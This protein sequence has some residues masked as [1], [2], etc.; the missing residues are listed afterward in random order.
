MHVSKRSALNDE[1]LGGSCSRTTRHQSRWF[2]TV[3]KFSCFLKLSRSYFITVEEEAKMVELLFS[4]RGKKKTE[5]NQA[6][7]G[8]YAEV[9]WLSEI[10]ETT[11]NSIRSINKVAV[12]VSLFFS[13]TMVLITIINIL[14]NIPIHKCVQV[15]ANGRLK[16]SCK[17]KWNF[18]RRKETELS[19]TCDQ[20]FA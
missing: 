17:A 8:T 4:S 19:A 16:A 1:R 5:K 10:K 15:L 9:C 18:F 14:N 6:A 3:R 20:P 12:S 11:C 13:Q 7:E 2:S